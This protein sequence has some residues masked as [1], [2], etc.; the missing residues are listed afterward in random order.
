MRKEHKNKT[1]GLTAAGR[2]Y[3]K[4]TEGANVKRQL[5]TGTTHRSVT[6]AARYAGKKCTMKDD[7]RRPPRT[8]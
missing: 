8:A 2:A 4:R 1:G 5:K 3:F 6:F 7:K